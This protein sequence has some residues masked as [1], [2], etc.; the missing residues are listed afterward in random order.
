MP[1]FSLSSSIW[2][3]EN[4]SLSSGEDPRW[5][6]LF[7]SGSFGFVKDDSVD[8]PSELL[9]GQLQRFDWPCSHIFLFIKSY[10][11]SHS[12]NDWLSQFFY[13]FCA[14]TAHSV[15]K[16]SCKWDQP[17]LALLLLEVWGQVSLRAKNH[18]NNGSAISS[19]GYVSLPMTSGPVMCLRIEALIWAGL[20][21]RTKR[22]GWQGRGRKLIV[23]QGPSL[24]RA[25]ELIWILVS[26][27][28]IILFFKATSG[29]A[30]LRE[31]CHH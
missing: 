28:P 23:D 14:R 2:W 17:P 22:T 15:R 7:T 24:C 1:V 18:S 25:G 16:M 13:L 30:S 5:I 31:F 8:T 10:S 27:F 20:L 26:E 21:C 3:E 4:Y 9:Q 11:H 29:T 19:E 6:H 12:F